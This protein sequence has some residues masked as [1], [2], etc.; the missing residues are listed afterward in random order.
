MPGTTTHPA[1]NVGS[2]VALFRAVV[3]AMTETTA[4]LAN[5]V[6][7]VSESSVECG[8]FAQLV[9]FENILAFRR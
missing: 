9:L 2:I 6:F 8:Q 7:I 3:L 1:N 5:L 4:V